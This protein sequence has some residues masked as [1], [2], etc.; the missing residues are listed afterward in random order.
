VCRQGGASSASTL[1]SSSTYRTSSTAYFA[2]TP[3][4]EK[5]VGRDGKVGLCLVKRRQ[6]PGRP[7]AAGDTVSIGRRPRRRPVS[8]QHAHPICCHKKKKLTLSSAGVRMRPIH[9]A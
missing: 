3:C 2:C 5:P 9:T 8:V 7:S 4:E 1:A 6:Q